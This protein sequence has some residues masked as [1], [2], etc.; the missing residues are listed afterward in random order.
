MIFDHTGSQS[1]KRVCYILRLLL[2]ACSFR[3]TIPAFHGWPCYTGEVQRWK[4][5][6]DIQSLPM[7]GVPRFFNEW[8]QAPSQHVEL[9]GL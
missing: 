6:D 4:Q 1:R 8:M 3:S 2:L 7:S 5:P 9:Q